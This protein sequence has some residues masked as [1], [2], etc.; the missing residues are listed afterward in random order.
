MGE[1]LLAGLINSGYRTEQLAVAEPLVQRAAVLSRRY[2]V[3]VNAEARVAATAADMVVLAVK[4]ADIDTVVGELANVVSVPGVEQLVVSLA[5]GIPTARL[6]ARLPEGAPVVRVMPNTPM[7]V[8]AGISAIAGGR[9]VLARH[10]EQVSGL[11][12][13]VGAVVIVPESQ[14]DAVTA[15][16][17][18]GPAYFFLV[19][20]AMIE[21]GV[22]M[23]LPRD[24]ASDL[25]VQTISGSAAMLAAG[26][27]G[28][29]NLRAAVTSPGGTTAA[30]VRV[31]ER[32]GIRS[33]F[34]D[35]LRAARDRSVEL[36]QAV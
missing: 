14:L 34:M 21:A 30:A 4:P 13:T 27:E 35:A 19:A 23:G 28:P 22:G 12:G 24:T 29:R 2:G 17:G 3:A 10:L 1:A 33:A 6:E 20:E 15:L 11:L 9:Y 18:S 26:G 8:G 25:V 5:A 36:G 7:L 31:L 32:A 16:S